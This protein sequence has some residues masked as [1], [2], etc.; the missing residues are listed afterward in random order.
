M[1]FSDLSS[2][3]EPLL[4]VVAVVVVA[5][6]AAVA[7][8]LEALLARSSLASPPLLA[9][10][11]SAAERTWTLWLAIPSLLTACRFPLYPRPDVT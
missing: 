11:Q 9:W 2:L 5:V 3:G 4:P 10:S 7:A 1:F 6:A 8:A